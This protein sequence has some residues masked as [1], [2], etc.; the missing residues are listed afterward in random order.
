MITTFEIKT[1]PGTE[2]E[3]EISVRV[4]S[5]AELWPDDT[6]SICGVVNNTVTDRY[7]YDITVVRGDGNGYQAYLG[8][9]DILE[10]E[11]EALLRAA[12]YGNGGF[13]LGNRLRR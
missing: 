7:G 4:G 11:A 3:R 9:D 6:G 8:T 12:A 1:Y 10:A 5:Y 2:S 13:P